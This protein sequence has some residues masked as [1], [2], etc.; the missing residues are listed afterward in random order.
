[1]GSLFLKFRKM[2]VTL[3]ILDVF[4]TRLLQ[5]HAYNLHFF[6]KNICGFLKN[7]EIHLKWKNYW[8]NY[9]TIIFRPNLVI[10]FCYRYYIK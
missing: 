4:I 8:T 9:W 1:M 5:F 6:F 2:N 3:Q 10:I 7:Q